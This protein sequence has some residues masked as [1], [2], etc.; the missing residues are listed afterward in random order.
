ML[1]GVDQQQQTLLTD[2]ANLRVLQAQA[3]SAQG[4]MQAIQAANQLPVR[5]RISYCRFADC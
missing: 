3:S 5:R 2:A 4:Q 1:K